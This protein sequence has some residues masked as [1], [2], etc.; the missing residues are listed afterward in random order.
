M[1]ALLLLPNPV[2]AMHIM[3]GYLPPVWCILW[4]IACL[5]FL[6]AGYRRIKAKVGA[7]TRMQLFLAMAGAYAFVLSA[8]KLPSVTGSSSHPTGIGLGTVLFGPMAMSLIGL[9]ILIFQAVLL[10]H[11]GLTTLGANTFS[12]AIAGPVIGYLIYKGAGCF[13]LP[14]LWAVFLA[15]FFADIAT[16]V[17]TS[18]QLAL[19]WPD[20]IG[21]FGAAL[22]KYL[23]IFA[24]TQ[25][26]IAVSEGILTVLIYNAM[27]AYNQEEATEG[28]WPEHAETKG[29]EVEEA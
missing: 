16:Y 29:A 17:V 13:R 21:G 15:A 19:A 10:A 9:L 25:L 7:D 3:E 18:L 22:V 12:M 11:G 8:L 14:K 4:G 1:L 27:A 2:H 20:P 28:S 26:P 24:A 6:F 5:P 23:G